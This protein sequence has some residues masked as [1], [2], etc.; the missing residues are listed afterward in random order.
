MRHSA[1]SG[2]PA[3]ARLID[4]SPA[5][6][7][8]LVFSLS[9]SS[10]RARLPVRDTAFCPR[11]RATRQTREKSHGN[12]RAEGTASHKEVCR[13]PSHDN[14]KIRAWLQRH[15]MHVL[16]VLRVLLATVVHELSTREPFSGVRETAHHGGRL[17]RSGRASASW[18]RTSKRQYAADV[19]V[20]GRPGQIR[21][22][23]LR[24]TVG[25]ANIRGSENQPTAVRAA[26]RGH[27]GRRGH[28]LGGLS[29]C[30]GGGG[31][32]RYGKVRARKSGV[33][34]RR[35]THAQRVHVHIK[36]SNARG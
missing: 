1:S 27:L 11:R 5:H 15:A 25:H 13:H 34:A 10:T 17:L 2:A 18:M 35:K 33:K 28:H 32:G 22:R 36:G 12:S 20:R 7:F 24:R 29:R 6:P 16:H 19:G 23:Q 3:A 9:V 21:V 14:R 30:A 8:F 4:V 31:G 26:R